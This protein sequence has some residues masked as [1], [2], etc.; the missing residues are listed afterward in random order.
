MSAWRCLRFGTFF[1]LIA[2]YRTYGS[3]SLTRRSAKRGS[4]NTVVSEEVA[5][6][7]RERAD[8][9]SPASA[10]RRWS[11]VCWLMPN[12]ITI[13]SGYAG[14]YSSVSALQF[15]LRSSTS[16]WPLVYSAILYGPLDTILSSYFSPVSFAL[17]T[18][19]N[20]ARVT[21]LLKSPAGWFRWKVMVF[22]S[23]EQT[24]ALS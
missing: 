17:G 14:R 10:C 16:C 4:L 22:P 1:A 12:F 18:G 15:G 9:S 8:W 5:R 21:V 2:M 11:L 23:G 24:T 13:L 19:A 6:L 20:D 3:N 7:S